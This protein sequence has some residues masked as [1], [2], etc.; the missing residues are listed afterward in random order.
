MNNWLRLSIAASV[1]LLGGSVVSSVY[2][3]GKLMSCGYSIF[4]IDS[5]SLKDSADVG[6]FFGGVFGAVATFLS[7]LL[8]FVT[9]ILQLV[10]IKKAEV[11]SSMQQF[12]RLFFG[13]LQSNFDLVKSLYAYTSANMTKID[14]LSS[15][16]SGFESRVDGVA[17]FYSVYK[18]FC[19]EYGEHVANVANGRGDDGEER[20]NL[21]V[22]LMSDLHFFREQYKEVFDKKY[23]AIGHCFR[24]VYHVLK[25]VDSYCVEE[26]KGA[27]AM[28]EERIVKKYKKYAAYIQARMSVFELAMLAYNSL[29]YDKS[30]DLLLKYDMLDNLPISMLCSKYHAPF[31]R[32]AVHK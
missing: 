1:L 28:D 23:M 13:L 19:H 7:S 29:V 27:I 17:V 11:D 24:N 30:Y 20:V 3:V 31:F 25:F 4:P 22:S 18:D 12:E 5:M 8:L 10:Q 2:Y 15:K 21:Y 32:G 26:V 6:Q 9:I 16:S 14:R